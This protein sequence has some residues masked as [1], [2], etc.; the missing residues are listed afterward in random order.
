PQKS[1]PVPARKC[2]TIGPSASAG[3]N[4]NA[5]TM[6]ITPISRMTNS[7]PLVGN[8]PAEGGT[9]FLFTNDPA[10]ANAGTII[11]KR[12]ASMVTPRLP[13]YRGVFAFSP[14]TAEPLFPAPL[15]NAY[16][17]SVKPCG[18][19]LLSDERPYAATADHAAKHRMTSGK[20]RM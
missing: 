10:I 15:V 13:W 20:I 6:T 18:P 16:R 9:I 1:F 17:I 12:P 19:L 8:V 14:A 3:K 5:P 7:G 4:V 11:R 2:S